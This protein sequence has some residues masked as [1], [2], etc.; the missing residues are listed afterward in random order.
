MLEVKEIYVISSSSAKRTRLKIQRM[1][2]QCLSPNL[3]EICV[4][5]VLR[6]LKKYFNKM[7]IM[8]NDSMTV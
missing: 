5:R 1:M 4:Q 7:G 8:M 2:K 3:I 6:Y